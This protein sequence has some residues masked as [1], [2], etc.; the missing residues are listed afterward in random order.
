MDFSRRVIVVLAVFVAA[1]AAAQSRADEYGY[2]FLPLQT[3]YMPEVATDTTLFYRAVQSADDLFA[4]TTEYAFP[5]VDYSRRNADYRDRTVAYAGLSLPVRYAA[6]LRALRA[7]RRRAAPGDAAAGRLLP[8]AGGDEFSF[9]TLPAGNAPSVSVNLTDRGYLAGVRAFVSAVFSRGWSLDAAL[10]ARTGRDLHVGGVFTDAAGVSLRLARRF[11]DGGAVSLFAAFSLSVRGM[12]SASVGEAFE[13]RGDNLYNPSWGWQDGRMRNS[14][15]RRDATPLFVASY[16]RAAGRAATL[17]AS[18]SVETG[19]R[20]YSSLGWYD[21]RTPMPDNYRCM[22]GYIASDH[23]AAV[24]A[25]AWRRNDTRYTQIDWPELYA[26]N[27]MAGGEA[28]YALEDRVRR[29]TNADAALRASIVL[30]D[31]LTVACGAA[32]GYS[33]TRSFRRMRDLLGAGYLTDID[34][35]LVDDDTFSNS[36]QN[37]LRHPDRRIGVGDRFGYD[38]A[39][40]RLHAGLFADTEYRAGRFGLDVSLALGGESLHR[41]GYYE[42]ELFPGEGSFGNSPS[43]RFTTFRAAV[44]GRYAFSPRHCVGMSLSAVGES[45]EAEDLFWNPQ[46]NNLMVDRPTLRKRFGWEAAYRFSSPSVQLEASLFASMTCDEI[47]TVRCYDDL[48]SLFCDVAA[49]GIDRLAYGLETAV[50]VRLSRRWSAAAAFS[51]AR[52]R[53]ASNPELRIVSDAANAPVA[54]A[55]PSHMGGCTQ[56][57]TPQLA[58]TVS[59]NYFSRGGW[60]VDL[61]L[62]WAGARYVTPSLLRRTERMS[63]QAA[64]SPEEFDA[65][66]RQERLPDAVNADLAVS[67]RWFVGASSR[68]SV[69]LSVRN[70]L[71]S[72]STVQSAYE[73]PRVRRI[74]AGV[75]TH[76]LPLPTRY[77]YAYPRTLY[78]SVNYTF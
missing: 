37:D 50:S 22:P 40:R 62:S 33:S 16:T 52:Y 21:A 45:P 1:E 42:K 66:V 48:E 27:R 7:D 67:K 64:S 2:P 65:I 35:Y 61:V 39:M 49:S 46:Y 32:A 57:G 28:V 71:D 5:F 74:S 60:G 54:D 9:P 29:L 20:S 18:V 34:F 73:S 24:V 75:A 11:D 10:D 25:D 77:L 59:A 58:A 31:R 69:M 41:H 19:S 13:L 8:A 6:A 51:A 23:S 15:V 55:S 56:G 3:D 12:R 47:A 53:Y 4:R 43:V 30:S 36:L 26:E 78:L 70:L 17:T 14:R 38:Y 76:Y 63:R 72:R 44:A 68:I